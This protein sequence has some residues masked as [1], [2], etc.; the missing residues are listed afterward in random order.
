MEKVKFTTNIDKK[1][2]EKTKIKAIQ[3]GKNVNGIIENLLEEYLKGEKEMTINN[4]LDN[5]TKLIG[6]EFDTEEIVI[7][8]EDY[9]YE[10]ESEII[11]SQSNNEGYDYVAYA[12]DV[13]APQILLK[14]E[15]GILTDAWIA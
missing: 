4:V 11:V 14:V 7:A 15:G 9:S 12:D 6:S 1:L 10:G 13:S 3:E 8:F 5:I 2:L